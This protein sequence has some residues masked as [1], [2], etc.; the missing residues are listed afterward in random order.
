MLFRFASPDEDSVVFINSHP[1]GIDEFVFDF[2]QI[3]LIVQI[4]L[5][6][7]RPIGYALVLLEP[8]DDLSQNFLKRHDGPF[9]VNA[10][11]ATS[12]SVMPS[13][14]RSGTC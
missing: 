4:K 12:V 14:G 9:S 3:L 1:S 11:S 7:Q 2:L 6:H 5:P 8:V 13:P 10:S